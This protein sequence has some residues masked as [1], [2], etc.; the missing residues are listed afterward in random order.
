MEVESKRY[1]EWSDLRFAPEKREEIY[2][3]IG[4]DM[5]QSYYELAL[6]HGHDLGRFYQ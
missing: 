5:N 2:K 1:L 4:E 3:Q 6:K